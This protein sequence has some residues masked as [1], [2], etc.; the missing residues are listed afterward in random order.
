MAGAE[1]QVALTVSV[2]DQHLA[3]IDSVAAALREAGM[4]VERSMATIGTITGSVPAS[5]LSAV[6]AT[7]GVADVEAQ[8]EFQLPPPESPIQ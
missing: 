7:Q 1:Q 4:S 8:R 5:R 6:R 2:D 3:R